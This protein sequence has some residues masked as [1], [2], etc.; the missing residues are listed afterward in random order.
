MTSPNKIVSDFGKLY[1]SSDVF[2]DTYYMGVP[3]VKC[4][5]D[6]HAYQEILYATRPELIVE[7]G[8]FCGGSAYM[9]GNLLDILSLREGH[10]GHVVSIDIRSGEG[11]D[12]PEHPRVEFLTGVSSTAPDTVDYVTKLAAGKRTMVILDSDHAK[13]HVVEELELYH[14]LV[15]PGCLLIVE[16]TNPLAYTAMGVQAGP[17]DAIRKWK[18][19][20]HGFER[21]KRWERWHFSFNP[22]GYWRRKT[23]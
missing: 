22:G 18:P 17:A 4:P 5:T 20:L 14:G 8:T 2:N 6:M 3:T 12:L 13:N 19:E 9:L 15:A 21:D 10:E 11:I 7:T 1:Y 23:D 16:D